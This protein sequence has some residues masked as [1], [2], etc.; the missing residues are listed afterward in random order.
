MIKNIFSNPKVVIVS[1]VLVIAVAVSL[2]LR[3]VTGQGEGVQVTVPTLSPE[4]ALTDRPAGVGIPPGHI[5]GGGRGA[6]PG[7]LQD[8]VPPRPTGGR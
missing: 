4:D 7:T 8:L 1:L 3:R 5:L 6:E 2:I